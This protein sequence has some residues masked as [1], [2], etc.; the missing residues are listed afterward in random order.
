[1]AETSNYSPLDFQKV[2]TTAAR[3]YVLYHYYRG[4]AYVNK[5]A[6]TKH[7]NEYFHVDATYDQVYKGYN[8]EIK[9]P[10]LSQAVNET[11]GMIVTYNNELAITPYFSNSDGRTRSWVE[12]WG[13]TQKPWLVSVS[14]PED[15]GQKLWGHG[16]GLSA[17]GALIMVRDKGKTWQETLKYFYTKTELQK[18]Y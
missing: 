11:S 4:L 15:N 9:M 5:E 12:V 1:M 17:R 10:K 16:V 14:V 7:E 2:M 8:S 18:A 3:T 13:G 6:S